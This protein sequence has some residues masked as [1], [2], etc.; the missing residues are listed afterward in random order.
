LKGPQFGGLVIETVLRITVFFEDLNQFMT[1]IVLRQHLIN[2][3]S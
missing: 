2:R 1:E 3:F